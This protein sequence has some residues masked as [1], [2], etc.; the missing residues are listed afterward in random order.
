[1]RARQVLIRVAG[2]IHRCRWVPGPWR[3]CTT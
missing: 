3:V 2:E 1:M